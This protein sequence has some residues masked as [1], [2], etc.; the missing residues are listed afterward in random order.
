[1]AT[2]RRHSPLM[3][4]AT[5]W[6]GVIMAVACVFFVLAKNTT[7]VSPLDRA[8]VPLSWVFGGLAIF[9]FVVY[10]HLDESFEVPSESRVAPEALPST[11]AVPAAHD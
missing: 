1:M 11:Q 8:S 3:Q 10:E 5:Y 6:I 7:L 2:T 9:A 4:D